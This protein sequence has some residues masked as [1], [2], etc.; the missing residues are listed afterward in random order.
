M[1]VVIVPQTWNVIFIQQ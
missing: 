1:K